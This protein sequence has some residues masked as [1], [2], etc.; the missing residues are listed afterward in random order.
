MHAA[1][2]LALAL[3]AA[4]PASPSTP[5][6]PERPDVKAHPSCRD[7]GMDREKFAATRMRIT[8]EDGSSVGLCSLRCAAVELATALDRAP[9]AIEVADAT[10]GELVPA[11]SAVWVIGGA[12]PGVMTA[13]AKWAFAD[14][15]RA[16]A[17]VREHGGTVATFDEAV[18][19]AFAD[20]YDDTRLARDRR[21]AKRAAGTPR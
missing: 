13:R 14:R 21:R 7:C 1:W 2:T 5:S 8:W 18:R 4:T 3:V 6:T 9:A 19:A 11:E 10:T 20:L 16:D 17:F 12:K 15:A